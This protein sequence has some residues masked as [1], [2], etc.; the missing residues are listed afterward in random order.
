M[1]FYLNGIIIPTIVNAFKGAY[2]V[3]NGMIIRGAF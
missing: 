1:K 3:V 2:V